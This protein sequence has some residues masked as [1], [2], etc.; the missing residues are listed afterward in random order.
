MSSITINDGYD[1]LSKKI[2]INNISIE[3]LNKQIEFSKNSI[4]LQQM[5][6]KDAEKKRDLIKEL[7]KV[8]EQQLSEFTSERQDL[9]LQYYAEINEIDTPSQQFKQLCQKLDNLENMMI[10]LSQK[11]QYLERTIPAEQLITNYTIKQKNNTSTAFNCAT[12]AL[13]LGQ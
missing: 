12:E 13:A 1:L 7:N 10:S 2:L 8:L 11:I 6:I 9:C 3:N 4:K 5:T